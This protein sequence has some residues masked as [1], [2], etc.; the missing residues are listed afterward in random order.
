MVKLKDKP[1]VIDEF[2]WGVSV[3]DRDS[4]GSRVGAIVALM[5][6]CSF[7]DMCRKVIGGSEYEESESFSFWD[8]KV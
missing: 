2:D 6:G 3:V 7:L 8:V 1:L 4:V 5:P